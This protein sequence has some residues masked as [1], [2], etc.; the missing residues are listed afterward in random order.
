MRLDVISSM[1]AGCLLDPEFGGGAGAFRGY[2][3]GLGGVLFWVVVHDRSFGDLSSITLGLALRAA[4]GKF[5]YN[6]YRK[7]CICR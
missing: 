1:D 6:S 3:H 4:L 5:S 2:A 7:Q